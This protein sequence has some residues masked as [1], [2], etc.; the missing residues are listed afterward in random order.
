MHSR[1][2]P[3]HLPFSLKILAS[4]HLPELLHE[5]GLL[6]PGMPFAELQRRSHINESARAADK[7]EDFSRRIRAPLPAVLPPAP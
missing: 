6:D 1:V 4:G 7:A 5:A 2:N 3:G